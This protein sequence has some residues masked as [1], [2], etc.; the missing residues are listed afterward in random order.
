M[1]STS[2]LRREWS[3]DITNKM[4]SNTGGASGSTKAGTAP[5]A[6]YLR[7]GQSLTDHYLLTERLNSGSLVGRL[8]IEENNGSKRTEGCN[9]RCR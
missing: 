6:R 9:D 4:D 5:R 7:P 1:T 8:I 2:S 3:R